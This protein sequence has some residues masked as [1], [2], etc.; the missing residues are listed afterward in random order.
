MN[1]NSPLRSMRQLARLGQDA[2]G[3]RAGVDHS[4]V[5]RIERGLIQPSA[6]ERKALCRALCV[7]AEFLF[8][9]STEKGK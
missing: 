4:R 1:K 9:A 3:R 5:S 6:R 2:L 8:P 7:P